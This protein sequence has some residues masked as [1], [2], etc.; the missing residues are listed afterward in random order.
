MKKI[1]CIFMALFFSLLSVAA[2]AQLPKAPAEMKGKIVTGG[3]FGGGF[4]GNC[5]HLTLSPQVGYR[6]TQGLE[7]GIRLGYSFNYVFI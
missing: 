2:I 5:L 3:H 6:L 4:S 1:K 7:A